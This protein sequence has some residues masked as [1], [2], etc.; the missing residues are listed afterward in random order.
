MLWYSALM[1]H[2]HDTH[3][4]A[5]T[6]PRSLEIN[7]PRLQVL[8]RRFVSVDNNAWLEPR[9]WL[10][11]LWLVVSL[12]SGRSTHSFLNYYSQFML[13]STDLIKNPHSKVYR[14]GHPRS[15]WNFATT[16]SYLLK[17][18]GARTS[19]DGRN[20]NR[21]SALSWP[22]LQRLCN[23]CRTSCLSVSKVAV[24]LLNSKTL[25]TK[26]VEP[27]MTTAAWCEVHPPPPPGCMITT[28]MT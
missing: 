7:G 20:G 4:L 6:A 24:L 26:I 1:L 3:R 11:S 14:H 2:C 5:T 13:Q 16:R 25:S 21:S 28:A 27:D 9:F 22:S 8:I 15:V 19:N 12:V 10:G 23:Y 17:K 18:L